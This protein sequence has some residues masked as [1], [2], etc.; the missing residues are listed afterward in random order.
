MNRLEEEK[1]I[2]RCFEYVE[3]KDTSRTNTATTL[4]TERYTHEGQFESEINA[5]FYPLPS[6]IMHRSELPNNGTA[7]RVKTVIGDVIV[8]R[9]DQGSFHVFRNVCRHRA[10]ELLIDDEIS[11][12]SL[13][14]PYHAWRYDTQGNLISVPAESTCFDDL[15][16]SENGL[17]QI[18]SAEYEGMI[19]MCVNSKNNVDAQT[20]VEELLS[21]VKS[22]LDWMSLESLEAFKS[23]AKTWRCNWKILAEGGMETYHFAKAHRKTIAPFFTTNTAVI[24]KLGPHHRVVIPSVAVASA[25]KKELSSVSL[26]DF[27]HTLLSLVPQSNFLIQEKH[28]DWIRV[29]PIS[30]T[31]SELTITSLIPESVEGLTEAQKNHW[32]TNFSITL[33]TLDEDF[34][35]GESIQRS[36]N[37]GAI[38]QI[39]LG[40]SEGA[41]KAFNDYVDEACQN[42]IRSTLKDRIP[43]TVLT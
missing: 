12:K 30:P 29:I 4:S 39:N 8:S 14:C 24:D 42:Q 27:T 25:Q 38:N 10:A 23:V 11:E 31:E 22:M 33:T 37:S 5:L 1:L 36:M 18:A 7:K 40:R 17:I 13:V 9:D 2:L 32:K 26:R 43:A 3:Q 15:D 28:V 35:L 6:A 19:W 41:L 21:P 34:E 16:K 20:L